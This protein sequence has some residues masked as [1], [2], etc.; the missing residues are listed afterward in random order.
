MKRRRKKRLMITRD[1]NV[2]L[3]DIISSVGMDRQ[4]GPLGKLLDA[5]LP[6]TLAFRLSMLTDVLASPVKHFNGQ[7]TAL[8]AEHGTTEDGQNYKLEGEGLTKFNEA[9]EALGREGVPLKV[10]VV[11][12]SDLGE[13]EILTPAECYVL[14]WLFAEDDATVGGG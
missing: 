13:R 1:I 11:R 3:F 4:P 12:V 7:R 8:L 10:P 2:E 6:A 14:R 5:R 9:M